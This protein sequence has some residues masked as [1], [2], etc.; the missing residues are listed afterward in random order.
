L[1]DEAVSALGDGLDVEG[2]VAVVAEESAEAE[3]VLGER[4]FFDERV[5]PDGFEE[6]FFGDEASVTA[7]EGTESVE[8]FGSERE[9]FAFREKLVLGRVQLEGAESVT[10]QCFL[11]HNG[12]KKNLKSL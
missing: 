7:D 5:G 2:A 12:S 4:G 11:G 6:L 3:D 10:T 1:S 8:S 9:R